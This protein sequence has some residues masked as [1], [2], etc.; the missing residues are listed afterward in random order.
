LKWEWVCTS[1]FLPLSGG[2]L[3][4]A[5]RAVHRRRKGGWVGDPAGQTEQVLLENSRPKVPCGP[6]ASMGAGRL[7]SIM[8]LPSHQSPHKARDT[9]SLEQGFKN[10]VHPPTHLF[11]NK[12]LE[13]VSLSDQ[14][15]S[16]AFLSPLPP[17]SCLFSL[18]LPF[19]L[20]PE[21][22]QLIGA[23]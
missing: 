17:L 3:N 14:L 4:A 11:A 5:F 7:P 16:P 6:V 1:C 18:S 8:P 22:M 21:L 23:S 20:S 13:G 19:S 15:W 12:R 9:T 10:F 2:D